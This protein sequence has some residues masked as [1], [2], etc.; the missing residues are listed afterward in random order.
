MDPKEKGRGQLKLQ[1]GTLGKG[2]SGKPP[3]GFLGGGRNLEKRTISVE[4][5]DRKENPGGSYGAGKRKKLRHID[6]T[7][8]E[9]K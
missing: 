1:T 7:C 8:V 6:L 5:A 3:K 2:Q 4:K 9:G